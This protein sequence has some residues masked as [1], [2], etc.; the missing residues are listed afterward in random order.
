MRVRLP[1][2]STVREWPGGGMADTR[3]SEGRAH[4]GVRVRVP[5]WPLIFPGSSNGR[6]AGSEPADVGSIPAPG[7]CVALVVKRTS[8][9]SPKEQVQVRLLA[10]VLTDRLGV[11]KRTARGLRRPSS[12]VR[13]L[14]GD[15]VAEPKV[16]AGPGCE[17]GLCGFDSHRPPC[18]QR[19]RC[20]TGRAPL[21]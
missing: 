13:L 18:E 11:V 20:S 19:Q 17:P 5:P 16:A 10:G 2:R 4:R 1:P 12:L 3:S 7:S 6:T 8:W 21:S 9:L 14:V 15:T